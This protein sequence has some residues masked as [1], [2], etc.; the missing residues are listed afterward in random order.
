VSSKPASDVVGCSQR[1]SE[2]EEVLS[3]LPII[4]FCPSLES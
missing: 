4:W 3:R 1:G 2:G